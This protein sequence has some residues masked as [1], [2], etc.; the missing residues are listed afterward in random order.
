MCP[1]WNVRDSYSDRGGNPPKRTPRLQRI[2]GTC[3]LS[4]DP[5]GLV[6]GHG[7]Q[8]GNRSNFHPAVSEGAVLPSLAS[9]PFFQEAVSISQSS[10]QEISQRRN[11][12]AR[13]LRRIPTV[14]M[15]R[16][17]A[18]SVMASVRRISALSAASGLP[19]STT[20]CARIQRWH[21]NNLAEWSSRCEVK[22][23]CAP[24]S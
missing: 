9:K 5:T 1:A 4:V 11:S 21:S 24:R 7:T 8:N 12:K 10:L 23:N 20:W 15:L 2:C 3:P 22:T 13:L 18:L 16:A 6:N 14:G 17:E 19:I